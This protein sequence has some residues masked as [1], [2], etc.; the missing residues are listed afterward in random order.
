MSAYILMRSNKQTG[1]FSKEELIQLGLKAYDLIWIEG[2]SALWRYPSEIPELLEY[3]P[4]VE[5]QP[6]DRFYKKKTDEQTDKREQEASIDSINKVAAT[7]STNNVYEKPLETVYEQYLPKKTDEQKVKK[8]QEPAIPVNK[9]AETVPANIV[10]EKPREI[11][12]E[13]YVP[14]K[15]VS[16]IMPKQAAPEKKQE[17]VVRQEPVVKKAEPVFTPVASSFV[18]EK[19][20]EVETKYSQTLDEIK[21]R[22]VKQLQQ[23]K[24]NT[25][26]KKF[27]MQMLKNAAVFIAI[28]GS[29]VLIGFVIKPKH[30][31]KNSTVTTPVQNVSP[32]NNEVIAKEELTAGTT[33][34]TDNVNVPETNK[35]ANNR[36]NEIAEDQSATTMSSITES[37]SNL[38]EKKNTK[39]ET[40]DLVINEQP[41]S[42]AIN[43]ANSERNKSTRSNSVENETKEK[44]AVT[45]KDIASSVSVNA[46][47]YKLRD[48]GG[49]RNLELTVTNDSK[50][51]LDNVLVELQYL[52]I[53]DQAL[54][55]EHIRFQSIEPDGKMTVKVPDNKRGAKLSYRIIKIEPFK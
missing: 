55:V 50:V 53:N 3:A 13:Q 35:T 54:K 27:I 23:R 26:Q 28:I 18:E 34:Q 45:G 4:V 12:Y 17:P 31:A 9:L 43:T 14:K 39:P 29:G 1:P 22:Y 24:Q 21:E 15:T 25:A 42:S 40:E 10:Y 49:F 44:T 20:P 16:V 41:L 6:Y 33:S 51:V 37:K 30:S 2:K 38:V 47:N 32:V 19:T 8:E 52:N 5:E 11:V 46:N 7:V 36:G 48:F